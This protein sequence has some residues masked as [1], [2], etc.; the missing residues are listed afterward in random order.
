M[1]YKKTVKCFSIRTPKLIYFHN[2][3][4]NIGTLK[5]HLFSIWDKW[6]IIGV[7]CPNT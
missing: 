1:L 2:I 6:K 5:A 4:L 7:R 3:K